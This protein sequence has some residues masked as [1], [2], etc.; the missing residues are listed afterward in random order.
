MTTKRI[1]SPTRRGQKPASKAFQKAK[2][3]P[4]KPEVHPNAKEIPIFW[5]EAN[6]ILANSGVALRLLLNV[7][8]RDTIMGLEMLRHIE[9]TI[10]DVI[11]RSN[12]AEVAP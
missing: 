2:A 10:G 8:A 1:P 3:A 11:D 5:R 4:T 9:R 12:R 7:N 6:A